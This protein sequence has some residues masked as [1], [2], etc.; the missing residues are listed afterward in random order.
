[1]A[2]GFLDWGQQNPFR[3]GG[4]GNGL[5]RGLTQCWLWAAPDEG[6]GDAGGKDEQAEHGH[7]HRH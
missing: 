4:L 1:M 3:L 7:G 2:P 6:E 5:L